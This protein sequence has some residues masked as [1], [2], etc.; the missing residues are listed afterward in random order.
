MSRPATSKPRPACREA[1]LCRR[2]EEILAAAIE[3][4]ALYGYAGTDTQLLADKLQISKGTLYRYFQ[5]K[6]ELF[7]AAVDSI[8]RQMCE[9]I[10]AS[11]AS[12]DDPWSNFAR[13]FWPI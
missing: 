10:D 1:T 11:Q 7:L 2:R 6:E 8:L 12:A 5:S 9:R 3:L 13:L 4:F